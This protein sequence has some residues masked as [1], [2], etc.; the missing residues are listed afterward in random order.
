MHASRTSSAETAAIVDLPG[1]V[2]RPR[3]A[4]FGCRGACACLGCFAAEG[5]AFVLLPRF[6]AGRRVGAASLAVRD[7]NCT[8]AALVL[9][10][11]AARVCFQR[12][13]AEFA[14][15]ARWRCILQGQQHLWRVIGFRVI[16]TL[17]HAATCA[18][19][20]ISLPSSEWLATL[21][22]VLC[23]QG[24]QAVKQCRRRGR[25]SSLA[26]AFAKWLSCSITL[27]ARSG[28]VRCP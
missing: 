24:Y 27:F 10:T 2:R 22:I 17:C 15:N 8:Q 25:T 9:L 13:N 5:A 19:V 12:Q 4:P 21:T 3:A 6:A 26:L 1:R 23:R 14:G 20:A 7:G 18:F 28:A 11:D 16:S